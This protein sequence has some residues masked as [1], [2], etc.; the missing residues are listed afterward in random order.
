MQSAGALAIKAIV[1]DLDGTLY[2]SPE[3]AATIQE[4][5]VIYM[6]A[7]RGMSQDETRELMGATRARLVEESGMQPTLSAVCIELGGT[8]RDLHGFFKEHLR[9]EAYLTRDE[10]V[11]VLLER[12]RTR[13]G[14]YVYTNNNHPVTERIID[15]LGFHALFSDVFAIDDLWRA[16][17]D[18]VRLEQIIQATGHAPGE[19]LFVGDRFDVDLRLPEQKGCPIYLSQSVDQLLRL[20]GL[21]NKAH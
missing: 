10:R 7:L 11:V 6:A 12:L 8:M 3:F 14:L 19:I 17:P 4:A 13:Y 16:K 2:V 15:C 18:D 5:A 1:F 20:D 9:P 21:L